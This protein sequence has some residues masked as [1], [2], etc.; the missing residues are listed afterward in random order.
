M[1]GHPFVMTITNRNTTTWFFAGCA[2][3][4]TVW[5]VASRVRKEREHCTAEVEEFASKQ[6]PTDCQDAVVSTAARRPR[7]K[8]L[9]ENVTLHFIRAGAI[10]GGAWALTRMMDSSRKAVVL[11]RGRKY[12]ARGA[13][14]GLVVA[15]AS[16]LKSTSLSD[17]IGNF[18]FGWM[19]YPLWEKL[20]TTTRW[21]SSQFYTT[22]DLGSSTSEALSRWLSK[23]TELSQSVGRQTARLKN[24]VYVFEA[25]VRTRRCDGLE[26]VVTMPG[27]GRT[28]R[29]WLSNKLYAGTNNSA[30]RTVG[31]A[32]WTVGFYGGDNEALTI[33]LNIVRPAKAKKIVP[34][35]Y[36]EAKGGPGPAGGGALSAG[37]GKGSSSSSSSS[38]S[39]RGGGRGGASVQPMRPHER[40]AS[41]ALVC[42]KNARSIDSVILPNHQAQ[43]MIADCRRFLLRQQWYVDRGLPWR[44]GYL[45]WGVPGCGKTSLI[46]AIAGELEMRVFVLKLSE[47]WMNDSVLASL[48]NSTAG[49]IVVM[50]DIDC[51]M[52][53]DLSRGD[54]EGVARNGGRSGKV[55]LSGLLNALDGLTSSTGRLLFMSTNSREALVKADPHQ[56][57]IRPGRIDRELEF[58]RATKEQLLKMFLHFYS[59][60]YDEDGENAE[61]EEEAGGANVPVRMQTRA[62]PSK[63]L[64][65]RALEFS[66]CVEEGK[67]TAADVLGYFQLHETMESA[68]QNLNFLTNAEQRSSHDGGGIPEPPLE[69]AVNLRRAI[70]H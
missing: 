33:F 47:E 3:A 9:S 27:S 68:V 42:Y 48:L 38:K 28:Q 11:S 45:L 61:E 65:E 19:V 50:E 1:H 2:A 46:E 59:T 55:T 37:A 64:K 70:S 32:R 26:V 60:Y 66:S 20:Q 16:F 34:I 62:A 52:G 40:G 31:I 12:L 24:N 8:L 69:G 7:A 29:L 57:L 41:W 25:N 67:Y 6:A 14:E 39:S 10:F 58:K 23:Q 13:E 21:A 5:L 43:E 49:G 17:G 51:A 56:A 15:V 63:E 35:E 30:S 44:R 22:V 54:E 53:G 36:F 4:G 18:F